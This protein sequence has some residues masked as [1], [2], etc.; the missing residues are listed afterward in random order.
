M[1]RVAKST[2]ECSRSHGGR[3]ATG[4]A[5]RLTSARER[6]PQVPL[7]HLGCL[8][9]ALVDAENVQA[10]TDVLVRAEFTMIHH[11]IEVDYRVQH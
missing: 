4:D 10:V 1:S 11:N 8:V 3:A 9:R 2:I 5:A 6:V 7:V